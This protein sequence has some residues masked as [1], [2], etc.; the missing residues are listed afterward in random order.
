MSS[1]YFTIPMM[2]TSKALGPATEKEADCMKFLVWD[3]TTKEYGSFDTRTEADK[4]TG[5]LNEAFEEGKKY[6]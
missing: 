2:F 5:L 4:L 6:G 1:F 3:Q